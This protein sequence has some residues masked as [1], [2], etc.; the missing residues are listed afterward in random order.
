LADYIDLLHFRAQMMQQAQART[1][2]F[3]ALLAPTVPI[4]APRID[5]LEA[6]ESLFFRT[7]PLTVRNCQMANFLNRPALS[8]PCHA[9]GSAPVGLMVIGQTGGDA[10]VFAI[11]AAIE[12]ALA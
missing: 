8:L 1:L 4:T 9:P 11:A 5:A 3:D 2:A 7:Q 10:Q 12:A 6:D